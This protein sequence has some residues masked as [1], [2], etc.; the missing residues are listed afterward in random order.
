MNRKCNIFG[1]QSLN[2]QWK[3]RWRRNLEKKVED[4]HTC[5]TTRTWRKTKENA[6]D[7]CSNEGEWRNVNDNEEDWL[8]KWRIRRCLN[9]FCPN[10]FT[11][12]PLNKILNLFNTSPHNS[13]KII[14]ILTRKRLYDETSAHKSL[15]SIYI[16]H[17]YIIYRFVSLCPTY[18]ILY[19]S[20]CPCLCC[21]SVRV[22]VCAT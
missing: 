20:S 14:L 4:S 12:W 5:S 13:N 19:I 18:F 9:Y 21:I 2:P 15:L 7:T 11:F 8:Q 3:R 16:I 10:F 22:N 17:N 6:H 1:H